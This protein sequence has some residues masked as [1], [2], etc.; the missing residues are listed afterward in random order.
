MRR[1][2][3]RRPSCEQTSPPPSGSAPPDRVHLTEEGQR[4]WGH[5]EVL[6]RRGLRICGKRSHI[7][8][9][10]D[11]YPTEVRKGV[12]VT[13]AIIGIGNLGGSL[14]RHLVDGGESVTL[15][16]KDEAKAETLADELG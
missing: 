1:S 2:T 14:A 7:S 6:A 9:L 3:G 4:A 15:A 13:T 16:A 10:D 11:A 12:M 8:A 5:P